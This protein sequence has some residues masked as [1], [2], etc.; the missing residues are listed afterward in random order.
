[1]S[2]QGEVVFEDRLHGIFLG[3][4]EGIKTGSIKETENVLRETTNAIITLLEEG[5]EKGDDGRD[6]NR[7]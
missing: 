1:M 5:Y 4:I 3:I 2:H 6:S 7:E